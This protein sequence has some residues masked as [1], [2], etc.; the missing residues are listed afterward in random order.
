M[1]PILVVDDDDDDLM[2][3]QE[4]VRMLKIERPVRYF[5]GGSDLIQHLR[6]SGEAPF[7]I[8]C[9]VNLP[10]ESGFEV[11]QQIT[12]DG[13]LKYISVPFIFWSTGASGPDLKK[14]Y[15]LPA[16]GF[17]LKPANFEE[18]CETLKLILEYWHRSQHPKDAT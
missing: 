2:L 18:L 15:D 14:A 10:G 8:L 9:D 17:F 3:I 11:K 1:N 12:D 5:K 16:Q 6:E 4:A 13:L 7:L